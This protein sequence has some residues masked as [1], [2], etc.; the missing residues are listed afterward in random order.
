[1]E[2]EESF[3]VGGQILTP[4]IKPMDLSYALFIKITFDQSSYNKIRYWLARGELNPRYAGD[5][6]R[7]FFPL[8]PLFCLGNR[9]HAKSSRGEVTP[10]TVAMSPTA[11][12][13][14]SFV[15]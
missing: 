14:F 9:S 10:L 15:Q 5:I 11:Q 7:S 3:G 12:P 8:T 6:S 4:K 1:M 2:K 13:L